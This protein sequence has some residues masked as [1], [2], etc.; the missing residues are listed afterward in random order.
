MTDADGIAFLTWALPRLHLRWAGFRRNRRQVIRRIDR[1]R[2]ELGLPDVA[3][4][5]AFLDEHAGEWPVLDRLCR[6]TIS[7][8]ARDRPVW[9]AL[10]DHLAGHATLRAWSA[11][12]GAGEEPYTLAIAWRLGHAGAA[13][14]LAT[15]VDDVQLERARVASYPPGASHELPQTWRAAAFE[16]VA[17]ADRVRDEYRS[18]V[19]FEHRDVRGPAPDG[20]FDLILCRNLAFTYFDEP[21]QLAVAAAFAAALRPGGALVIGWDEAFPDGTAFAPRGPCIYVTS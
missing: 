11:G 3:A 13:D 5:R 17:G 16:R 21:L 15:D 12:C 6:A 8:F 10:V 2:A 20:P 4:Y 9:D 7:R 18:C 1:R 19:R 14:I